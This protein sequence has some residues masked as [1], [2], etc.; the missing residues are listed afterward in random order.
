[1]LMVLK[2]FSLTLQLCVIR[3]IYINV[4]VNVREEDTMIL[5]HDTSVH[6]A[7]QIFV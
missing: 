5:A 2:F 3:L 1:M 7:L 6:C 4:N